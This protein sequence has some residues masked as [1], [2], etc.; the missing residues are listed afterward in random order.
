LLLSDGGLVKTVGFKK[1]QYVGDPINAVKIFNEKEVDEL[2]LLDI[3]ASPKA[4][5]PD[6][7]LVTDI[8]SEAFMPIAYGGGIKTV[9]QA[10]QI[11][12]SGVEKIILNSSALENINLVNEV[13]TCLGASSTVVS[14]DV[15]KDLFGQYRIFNPRTRKLDKRP[16][17]KYIDAI[18]QAGAGELMLNDIARE[19]TYNGL[20]LNL[21]KEINSIIKLPLVISGGAGTLEHF[22][23]A[24][25]LGVSGIA[26][27]SMFI[28]MGRHRAVMINYPSYNQLQEVFSHAS[29]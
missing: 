5:E 22:V 15:K 10:K 17:R 6:F 19:G 23:E 12:N 26:V 25:R 16:L 29:I 2:I 21:L 18:V 9:E 24:S 8:V 7:N 13:S 20:N 4:K 27:G 14:I 28:Y 11:I 3:D 1:P